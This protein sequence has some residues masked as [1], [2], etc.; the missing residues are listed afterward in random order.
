MLL[1]GRFE[2]QAEA[3]PHKSAFQKEDNLTC[4]RLKSKGVTERF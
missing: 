2:G 3:C 4:R 1:W